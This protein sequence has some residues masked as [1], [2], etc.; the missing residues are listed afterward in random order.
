MQDATMSWHSAQPAPCSRW[1]PAS[2]TAQQQKGGGPARGQRRRAA[3]YIQHFCRGGGNSPDESVRV[4]VTA[5][6]ACAPEAVL[7]GCA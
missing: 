4:E 5:G 6:R 3:V 2:A 1:R 7:Q